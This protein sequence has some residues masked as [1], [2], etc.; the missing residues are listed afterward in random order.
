MSVIWRKVWFD[1]WSNKAR[2]ILA[3][4]S[5]AVGVFAIGAIF[6]MVDQLLSGMD[7]A[8]QAVIPSHVFMV[9]NQPID[10]DTAHR[11]E[12][13][14]G[15]EEIE[16]LNEVAVRYKLK[17]EDEWQAGRLIMRDDYEQQ[18]Y[19]ILLLKEG[20]WPEKDGLGIERLSSQH[21]GIDIGDKVPQIIPIVAR[22][23]NL[24]PVDATP[25]I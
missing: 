2:T 4:L 13:I 1:L 5:I 22:P 18:T 12:S 15:I 6:G 19:D 9:L 24:K 11:L 8:H 14:E 7:R 25:A 17:P 16:V 21:F 3:V 10:K 20:S 23:A